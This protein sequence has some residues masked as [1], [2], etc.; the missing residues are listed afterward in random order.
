MGKKV[1]PI[2]EGYQ[3]LTPMLTVRNADQAIAFYKRAFGAEERFRMPMPDGK[4]IAHAELGFGS[5]IFMLSDEMPE[6]GCRSPQ[7]LEGTP[8]SFYVYVND[9][10]AAFKR[11]VEAGGK[12]KMAVE[13]MFWGDRSGTI[14]D[15]FGHL[16]TLATHV[17][18]LTPEEIE[19]RGR[20]AFAKM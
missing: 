19:K 9:V 18:D 15:P 3:T 6:H 20:E 2:P 7:A 8:V 14:A 10:D 11:A 5:S 16:W 13:N 17:E 4:G 12:V 1:K